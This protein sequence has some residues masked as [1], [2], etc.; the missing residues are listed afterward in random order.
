MEKLNCISTHPAIN[1]RLTPHLSLEAAAGQGGV[2][3][4]F[5]AWE[6]SPVWH[7]S[8]LH[9]M[10]MVVVMVI[11][12]IITLPFLNSLR[13]RALSHPSLLLVKRKTR[14]SKK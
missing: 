5:R 9:R 12:L 1:S 8:G 4:V 3:G 13:F 11:I 10:M 7:M 6:K 14:H 2:C